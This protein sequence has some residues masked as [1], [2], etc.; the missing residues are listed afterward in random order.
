[1]A[2]TITLEGLRSQLITQTFGRRL[3]FEYG[4]SSDSAAGGEAQFLA[5]P[6]GLRTPTVTITTASTLADQIPAYGTVIFQTSGASTSG[7]TYHSLQNPVPGMSVLVINDS[8]LAMSVWLNGSTGTTAVFGHT[9]PAAF[10][11]SGLTTATAVN[12][13]KLGTWFRAVGLT[14]AIWFVESNWGTTVTTYG[15]SAT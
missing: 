10:A 11:T 9:Q 5:G 1:M 15:S 4:N 12:L 6:K 8:T 7:T 2:Q 3:G 14:T 13:P